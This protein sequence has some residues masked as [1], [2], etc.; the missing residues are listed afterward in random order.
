[1]FVSTDS[2]RLAEKKIQTKEVNSFEQILLPIKNVPDII[3]FFEE[4]TEDL[5]VFLEENQVF[6]SYKNHLLTSRVISGVFPDYK[7][8]IPKEF[9]TEIVVL[10]EDIINSLRL[11]NIFTDKFN[12]IVFSVL[13]SKKVFT[14][15]SQNQEK[16][17]NLSIMDAVL[18]G[19]DVEI[20]FNYKYIMD[21]FQSISSDSI[22]FSLAG[23]GRPMLLRGISDD[24][25]RYIVMPMN[26]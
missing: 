22:S 1:M 7:Q 11:S 25:F 23:Q 2:F 9:K 16:G 5:E 20:S 24:S 4:A 12:Q 15:K 14:L 13:P 6:F 26:R 3:R 18:K 21:A 19:E 17:E 8:I 10:K